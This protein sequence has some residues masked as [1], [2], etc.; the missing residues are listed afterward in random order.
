M[1]WELSKLNSLMTL[2]LRSNNLSGTIPSQLGH[3][4]RIELKSNRLEGT[5]PSELFSY[6]AG[7]QLARNLGGNLLTGT[8]PTEIG[9]SHLESLALNENKLSG[10]IPTEL[11][12]A[13]NLRYFIVSHN[14]QVGVLQSCSQQHVR[15]TLTLS[16][17]L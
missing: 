15:I 9:I 12:T 13:Y 17:L 1:L 2:T 3:I 8:I 10:S 5:I 4:L 11:S 16:Y 14:A 7:G 6:T